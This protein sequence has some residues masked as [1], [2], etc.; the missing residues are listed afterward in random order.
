MKVT[1]CLRQE[2]CSTT[3]KCPIHNYGDDLNDDF[4]GLGYSHEVVYQDGY[5]TEL[6]VSKSCDLM[7]IVTA[8]KII[9]PNIIEIPDTQLG[10][11]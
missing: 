7:K 4:C 6:I 2:L 9:T 1:L 3:Y 5:T 8:D 11:Q 10:G